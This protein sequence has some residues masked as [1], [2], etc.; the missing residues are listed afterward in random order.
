[1]NK[2]LVEGESENQLRKSTHQ[3]N[4]DAYFGIAPAAIVA[5]DRWVFPTS[6]DVRLTMKL[7]LETE[8]LKPEN[9]RRRTEAANYLESVWGIPCATKTLAK[10]AVV[11]GGPVFRKAGRTPLY[12]EVALDDWARRKLT[13]RVHSTSELAEVTK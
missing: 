9:L 5:A 3:K 12:P 6:D 2:R 1:V 7:M 13:K 11:G 10:L 4:R 8:V